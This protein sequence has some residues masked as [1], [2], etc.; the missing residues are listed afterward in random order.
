MS[1]IS[2]V[3][4]DDHK[5]LREGLVLVFSQIKNMDVAGEAADGK[6]AISLCRKL[7]PDIVIMDLDMPIMNG[8]EATRILS[9]ECQDS[10]V[11]ILSMHPDHEYVQASLQA[12]AKGFLVKESA[13]GELVNA[14]K[15]VNDG[16]AYFSPTVSST[17]IDT[18]YSGEINKGAPEI[19]TARER[20]ILQLVAEGK[21]TKQI[22]KLL[23]ISVTTISKHR[24]NILKKLDIHDTVGL[25]RYAIKKGIISAKKPKY[26]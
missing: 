13:A 4:V 20:E 5:I 6:E 8:I 25:V 14:V 16:K 21:T 15:A 22:A 19:L 1:N 2:I 18:M 17:I 23:F 26:M 24:E 11:I 12:G 7:K 10:K 9:K 3:I